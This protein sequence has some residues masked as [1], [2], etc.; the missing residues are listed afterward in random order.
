MIRT[1]IYCITSQRGEEQFDKMMERLLEQ[2]IELD[3]SKRKQGSSAINRVTG[4]TWKVVCANDSGRGIKWDYAL[5]DLDI[6]IRAY[7]TII[8][9]AFAPHKQFNEG[10]VAFY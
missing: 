7:Q 3:I 10:M 8:L 9:P 5:V 4:D 6:S 2:G 1:V